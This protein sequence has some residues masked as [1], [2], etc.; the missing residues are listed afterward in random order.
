MGISKVL[1]FLPLKLY[2]GKPKGNGID[3]VE[4]PEDKQDFSNQNIEMRENPDMENKPEN[5][6]RNNNNINNVN[7]DIVCDKKQSQTPTHDI[8][9][10]SN[11]TR[12]NPGHSSMSSL[13]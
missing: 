7:K 10:N 4:L 8:S 12:N 5:S 13:Y 6:S 1:W 9:R 3:W 2:Y 11:L